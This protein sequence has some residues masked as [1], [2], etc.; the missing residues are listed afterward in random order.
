LS[1]WRARLRNENFKAEELRA[2]A[3]NANGAMRRGLCPAS[4]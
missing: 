1:A 3:A 2:A 4:I